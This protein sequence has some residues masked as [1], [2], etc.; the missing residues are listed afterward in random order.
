V[1]ASLSRES[2]LADAVK[3]VYG[4]HALTVVGAGGHGAVVHVD[5]TQLARPTGRAETS[6]EK[7]CLI[8]VRLKKC[9]F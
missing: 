9:I 4:I 8:I 6:G 3:V 2:G 1:L 5:L 7:E